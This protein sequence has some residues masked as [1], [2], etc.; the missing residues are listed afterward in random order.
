MK[1]VLSSFFIHLQTACAVFV[2]ILVGN[3]GGALAAG[4]GAS[5]GVLPIGSDQ[6]GIPVPIVQAAY[7]A[8]VTEPRS[9]GSV[10]LMADPGRAYVLTT[11]HAQVQIAVENGTSVCRSA[12]THSDRSG[13]VELP[14]AA[15]RRC[16]APRLVVSY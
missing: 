14:I 12:A 11:P 15:T 5:T 4:Q 1:H 13:M 16:A 9:T 7:R 10:W 2:V 8:P 6:A 3:L